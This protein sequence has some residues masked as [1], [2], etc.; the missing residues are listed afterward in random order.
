MLKHVTSHSQCGV[1]ISVSKLS[2][3][4]IERRELTPAVTDS[5][6]N[7][8]MNKEREKSEKERQR[9]TPQLSERGKETRACNRNRINEREREQQQQRGGG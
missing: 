2:R 5:K 9:L 1:Y 7:F 8:L 4:G 6:E 3:G